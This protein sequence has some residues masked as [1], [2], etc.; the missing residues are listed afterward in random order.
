MQ[1]VVIGAQGFVGSAFCR[2]LASRSGIDLLPI[3]RDNYEQERGLAREVVIDAS[4]NSKKYLADEDPLRDFD[5]SVTHRLKTLLDYPARCH[6]HISSV[7]VYP[8]LTRTETTRES[9]PV[10]RTLQSLYGFH[11]M[12]AEDVV[13]RHAANWLII[14]L[15]GMVGPG[16]RKNP[17]YDVLNRKPLRIHPDS[18][19]QFM[20]TD[21]VAKTCW[22]L[23]ERGVRQHEVNVCGRG[24]ISPREISV[25][26][27]RPL[28]LSL[29]P[30]GTLPRVVDANV[31]RLSGYSPIP[32][33][34]DTV[35][36]FCK[37]FVQS[38]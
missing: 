7:D 4:G 12:L 26:A 13:R 30:E 32:E 31:A 35:R 21:Q 22:M 29:L 2:F 25:M 11:K 34:R 17:V 19:Y 36:E 8:D 24:H 38:S 16:L 20:H 3:T 14:R 37:T 9:Q 18:K 1:V 15:A 33:T 28:D 23:F 6:V 27:G 10:D 5:L